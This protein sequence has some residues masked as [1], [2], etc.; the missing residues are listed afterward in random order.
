[1]PRVF[2]GTPRTRQYDGAYVRSLVGGNLAGC[3]WDEVPGQPA[4]IARNILVDRFQKKKEYDFIALVDSD[5]TWHPEAINRLASRNL[6]FVC[7]IFFRRDIPPVP[8][9]G[10]Y[11][12]VSL[13]GN[14]TYDFGYTIR[15][16]LAHV[17][18]HEIGLEADN[19]LVL[20]ETEND[21]IP[22]DG[23]GGHF[24][25]I[26]RD[27]IEAIKPPWFQN[28]TVS[29]GEDFDFCRK[30]ET[31]GFKMY[32]DLSVYTG[33]IVGE[34]INF[35]LRQFLMFYHNTDLFKEH[36]GYFSIEGMK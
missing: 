34:G 30:V 1:M 13:Q 25:L 12:G 9:I 14:I 21:L 20:P 3:Y 23:C 35:G 15:H 10:I 11:A 22:I 6:P 19:E 33:H 31:A 32:A 18:R 24:I 4:D 36:P 28:T 5:A 17:Q 27:V 8:T 16:V 26:R 29:A 2:I 7:G